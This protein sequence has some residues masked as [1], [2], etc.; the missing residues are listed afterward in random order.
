M[1]GA[2]PATGMACA[3]RER[4]RYSPPATLIVSPVT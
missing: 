1:T 2:A 4:P 3:G